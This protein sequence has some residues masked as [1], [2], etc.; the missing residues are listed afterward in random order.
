M[1]PKHLFWLFSSCL[2]AFS[3]WLLCEVNHCPSGW[4]IPAHHRRHRPGHELAPG[5]ACMTITKLKPGRVVYD[6]HSRRAGNTTLRTIGVWPVEIVSVDEEQES[7]R[8]RWNGN[9][10]Q[11]YYHHTWSKWRGKRPVLVKTGFGCHRL[12][13]RE[14][15]K[16][17]QAAVKA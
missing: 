17:T 7:V 5:S 13:T 4:A 1:K 15:I 12:A 3:T 9:R 2:C 8:A 14:E 6:V 10:E 11:T 16:Q